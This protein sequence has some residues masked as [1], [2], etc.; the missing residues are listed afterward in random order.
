VRRR[1]GAEGRLSTHNQ[2]GMEGYTVVCVRWCSRTRIYTGSGRG[3]DG[4]RG[5]VV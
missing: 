3:L 5:R 1:D 4:P 2:D